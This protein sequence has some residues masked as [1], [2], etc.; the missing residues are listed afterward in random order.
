MSFCHWILYVVFDTHTGEVFADRL[1]MCTVPDCAKKPQEEGERYK[2][3]VKPGEKWAKV[4]L[5]VYVFYGLSYFVIWAT[6]WRLIESF[7]YL[8]IV[9]FGEALPERF[10]Q[11]AGKVISNIRCSSCL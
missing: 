2:G 7:T 10:E 4:K 9:F 11:L 8:D 3:L 6:N 5:D 1:P